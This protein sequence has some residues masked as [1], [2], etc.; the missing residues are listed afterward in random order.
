[1]YDNIISISSEDFAR[2]GYDKQEKWKELVK[3]ET[4]K[5]A[6]KVGI[7]PNRLEYVSAVHLKEDANGILKPNLHI[8]FWDKEQEIK[9]PYV[10]TKTAVQ[11]RADLIKTIYE[12]DIKELTEIK[13]L[14]RDNLA[15]NADTFYTNFTKP[16]TKMTKKQYVQLE[17]DIKTNPDMNLSK[18]FDTNNLNKKFVDET[19]M[20]RL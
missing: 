1:M 17:T 11:I 13:N 3:N 20:K 5:I 10:H 19:V 8:L 2:L 4:H 14:A 15:I 9:K 16:I 12:D 7:M 6:E 18:M